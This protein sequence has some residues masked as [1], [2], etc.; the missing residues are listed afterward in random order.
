MSDEEAVSFEQGESVLVDFESIEKA[1]FEPLPRGRYSCTIGACEYQLSKEKGSPMW[2][3]IL[4][5]NH[6]DYS[7]RK[8]FHYVVF[9][10]GALPFAKATL[11]RIA[12]ELLETAFHPDDPEVVNSMVGRRCIVAVTIGEYNGEPNNNV[13]GLYAEVD[14]ADDIME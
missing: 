12:P 4:D 5:I 11:E 3:L 14:G 7:N 1:S 6:P 10:E 8:L 2:Q 13:K 9:S